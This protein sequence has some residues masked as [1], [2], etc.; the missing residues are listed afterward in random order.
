MDLGLEKKMRQAFTEKSTLARCLHWQRGAS[1][2]EGIAYLG[3]AAIVVL[4]AVSLLTSAFGNA[5]S[6]RVVEELVS[7]R[8]GVKK[9]YMG[10]PAGYPATV[11]LTETLISARVFPGSLVTSGTTA[12]NS[13]NGT[14]SVTGNGPTFTISYAA[15]PQAECI[16]ILSGATGWTEINQAGG[17]SITAFP[18]TPAAA[19]TTCSVTAAAGNTLNF[20]AQ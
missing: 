9:L 12:T 11:N 19:A 8:T 17:N 10:Q 6:N 7:I 2:L 1:L 20:I 13:W 16:N 3:I 4:G 5:Q 18:V 15:V 14:V